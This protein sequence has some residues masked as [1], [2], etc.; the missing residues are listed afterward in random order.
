MA[1]PVV[2][3]RRDLRRLGPG[4]RRR[5]PRWPPPRWCSGPPTRPTPT[6]CSRHARQ[7]YTFAD[8]VRTQA[9]TRLH[10]RRGRASTT[11]VERL[12]TTRW[13]GARS[14]CTGPPARPPTW[15][16]PRATTTTS[17]PSRRP[18][19][20]S[21]KWTLDWDDKH[22]GTYV[23]MA[24]L[25]GE[26]QYLDD[27]NRW[28]D[29]WTVGVNGR[30]GRVLAGRPGRA[31]ARGGRCAT[32]RTPPSL[33]LVYADWIDRRHPQDALPRLRRSGRSTT[34]SATTRA[35]RSYVIGFGTN[36]PRN[37]HHRTAH[38]SWSDSHDR[39]RSTTGTSSTARWSAA[40]RRPTTPTP[41]TAATTRRT[42]S[43]PTTTPASPARWSGC[44]REYGGTPARQLPAARDA[45]HRRDHRGD[46]GDAERA[47]GPPG[48]RPSSTTSPPSRRGR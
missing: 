1:R 14:G 45:G 36:P 3:D 33:A 25:T 7:L 22:F 17:A 9:T 43:P 41:T 46:H 23:L 2:P 29:Y 35:T 26:Q 15:P 13:S 18:P 21:Y 5:R 20:A 6:R 12:P 42:R 44:T 48:S 31:R 19:P 38:G 40:R 37:P 4:R 28:L 24:K 30:E 47:A 16:R 10:H 27:A 34:R 32:R 11:V 39:A 8:T